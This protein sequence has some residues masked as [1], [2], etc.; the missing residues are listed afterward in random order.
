MYCDYRKDSAPNATNYLK[1][2]DFIAWVIKFNPSGE[3]WVHI[4]NSKN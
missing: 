2:Q 4:T 3:T 1:G